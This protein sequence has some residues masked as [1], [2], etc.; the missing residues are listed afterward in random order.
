MAGVNPT[1][2]PLVNIL[3]PRRTYRREN[4]YIRSHMDVLDSLTDS[5]SLEELKMKSDLFGLKM[6]VN[7]W[8][9][10]V[11]LSALKFVIY[12]EENGMTYRSIL[13]DIETGSI[14]GGIVT[15][16]SFM[17]TLMRA[18]NSTMAETTVLPSNSP[19]NLAVS[20]VI[21]RIVKRYPDLKKAKYLRKFVHYFN[22]AE[23]YD[24]LTKSK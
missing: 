2:P 4:E 8:V 7:D 16:P 3:F 9:F 17:S 20:S 19:L 23:V 15:M 18:Y 12:H 22:V 13:E 6:D 24:E 1:F 11:F 10:V 21:T 14:M 5:S